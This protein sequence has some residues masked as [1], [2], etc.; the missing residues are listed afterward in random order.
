MHLEKIYLSNFKNYEEANIEFSSFVN[1]IVGEN[2]SGKTNLLDAIYFLALS[3]SAFQSQDSLCIKHGEEILMI[4]GI[5][6]KNLQKH[7]ITCSVGKNQ[8]KVILHEKKP[9]E[10]L[11]DHIGLYP[12][13]LVS[14]DDTDFI[15]E[16]SEKRRKFFDA[17]LAQ[18]DSNYLNDYQKYNKILEQRNSLLKQF[19][20]RNYIDH[21]LLDTYSEPLVV[22]AEKIHAKRAIFIQQFTP[23]FQKHYQEISEK[24]ENVSIV[25]DS[26]LNEGNFSEIFLRNRKIDIKAQ[27]TTKGTHKDDYIFEID[28]FA[29]RKFGSQGQQKSFVLALRLAQF[30]MIESFKGFK[31]LLLLD[32]IFDKLDDRR[33]KKL[34]ESIQ[35]RLFGQVFITDAVPERTIK[36]FEESPVEVKIIRTTP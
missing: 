18:M 20:D 36:A 23:I 25:Y 10:K 28:G 16:G 19:F 26:E 30:E 11:T 24:R 5:F 2:G 27:R 29:V 12:V 34:I 8:K 7:Q 6:N 9:Y 3:K 4:D 31:P 35:N 17:V 15:K 32:D 13:V 22:L 14:P 21:E 33:I 1:C